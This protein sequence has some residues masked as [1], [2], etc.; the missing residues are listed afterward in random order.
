M[1]RE[2]VIFLVDIQSYYASV[3]KIDRPHLKD[4]PLVVAGDPNRRSGVVLAACPLAK[5]FH[6][7]SGER[8]N[9][10]LLKCPTIAIVKPRMQLY[11]DLSIQ[12]TAILERYTDLV[13][14]FS[15]DEQFMDVTGSQRIFGTPLEIARQVQRD[16]LH[17]TGMR[18][19]VGIGKN[20]VLAKLACDCFAKKNET[21]IYELRTEHLERDL[22]KLP[23]EKMFGVGSR[24]KRNLASI[25][26]TTIGALA[27]YPLNLLKRKWGINGHVLWMTANG[28]DYSLVTTHSLDK[29]KMIG[30]GMT[31]PRDYQDEEEIKIVLLELCEEVARRARSHQLA[32]TTVSIGCSGAYPEQIGFMRQFTLEEATNHAMEIFRPIWKLFLKFWNGYPVRRLSVSLSNLV[33]QHSYQLSIF[34]SNRFLQKELDIAMDTIRDKYGDSSIFRASSLKEAGQVQERAK[35]IGGHYK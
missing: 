5:K 6:I 17:E 24:M 3:E 33:D 20:K 16:I 12:I 25:G 15:I 29:Q 32:G 2:S 18:A 26:I 11:I 9:E 7:S 28:I 35:K 13:E 14:P 34:S 23:V 21:G 10:A 4:T 30:N 1:K 19:R 31:L 8:L 22:W 27:T